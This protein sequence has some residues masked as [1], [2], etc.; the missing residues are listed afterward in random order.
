V[1]EQRLTFEFDAPGAQRLDKFLVACLPDFSRSRL[2]ALIKEGLVSVKGVP[3]IKTGQMLEGKSLVEVL[4]PAPKPTDLV[5]EQIPLDILFETDD[6]MVV[7][8]PAGMVVHPAAGHATGTLVHAA[9]AHAPDISGVGGEQRPGVVHRLDKETSGVIL[10]A[11][12]DKT[13]RWLQ[14][15]F[16]LRKT[17]KV[18]LALVDGQPPTPTGRIEAA[19]GRSTKYRNLMAV[20]AD[21][22]GRDS[23]TEYATLEAFPN[24]TLLEARPLSGRTHQIRLHLQFIGCPVTGDTV[25]GR[26]KPTL[27]IERHFLHAYRLTIQLLGEREARTFEAPLPADL[28]QI[29]QQLRQM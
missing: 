3:A 17:T 10:L 20:V 11:K 27:P 8:K 19:I 12:N 5:P 26:K 21:D 6:L 16:R 1:N 28:T 23:I 22:K 2:Q 15:R 29:L 25:Y 24:H 14:D 9:L 7:N 4:I 13:H 18:Y